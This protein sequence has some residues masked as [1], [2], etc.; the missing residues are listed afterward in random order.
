MRRT[1][2]LLDYVWTWV[3]LGDG[4]SV[5]PTGVQRESGAAGPYEGWVARRNGRYAVVW[6]AR[7]IL[8]GERGVA[9][10]ELRADPMM[11]RDAVYRV[12]RWRSRRCAVQMLKDQNLVAR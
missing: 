3:P 8:H 6:V 2:D 12:V 4:C 1:P 11:D 10:S 7:G 9:V 5:A